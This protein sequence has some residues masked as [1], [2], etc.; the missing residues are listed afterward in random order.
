MGLV[1]AFLL[2]VASIFPWGVATNS[3]GEQVMINGLRGDGIITIILGALI[4]FILLIKQIPHWVTIIF[5]AITLVIG[6]IDLYVMLGT[7]KEVSGYVGYGLYL[8]VVAGLLVIAGGFT[9]LF[10]KKK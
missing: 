9:E 10:K 2:M 1:G 5:G 3:A 4:V 6:S 8:T 7:V